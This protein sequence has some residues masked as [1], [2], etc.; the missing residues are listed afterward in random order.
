MVMVP[1]EA[2]VVVDHCWHELTMIDV[3]SSS[4]Q[5]KERRHLQMTKLLLLDTCAHR[6]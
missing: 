6:F 5:S 4:N 3:R 1:Q 2:G